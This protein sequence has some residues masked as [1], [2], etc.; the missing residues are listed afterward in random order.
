MLIFTFP[1]LTTLNTSPAT[2]RNNSGVCVK[3]NRV[4]RVMY[5]DP[6]CCSIEG[7]NGGTGPDELPKD[8]NKPCR[9]KQSSDPGNVADPIESYTTGSKTPF[10]ILFTSFTKSFFL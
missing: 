5:N 4:G 8:T 7:A 1:L 9:C 6:R 10:V 2:S 3:S